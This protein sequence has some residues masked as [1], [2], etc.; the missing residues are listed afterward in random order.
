MTICILPNVSSVGLNRVVNSATS[1]R[2]HT[3]RLKV[4]LAKKAEKKSAVAMVKH[5]RQSGCAFQ[6]TE[7]PESLPILRKSAK[8]LG[9]LRRVRFTKAT[10]RHPKIR[11]N[12]G[13]S[14]GKIRVKSSSSAQSL[15]FAI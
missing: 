3:G 11:E 10:Q 2:L 6:D 12:K 8:V 5:A 15:R 1:A 13:P 14:L 4:N 9:S 7:P